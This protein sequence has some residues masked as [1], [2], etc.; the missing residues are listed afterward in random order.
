M[1]K[2]NQNVP[3]LTTNPACG[4]V[5]DMITHHGLSQKEVATAMKISPG[6]LSDII[7]GKKGVSAE[8]ALR[9]EH[10]LGLAADWLL[11]MQAHYDYCTAY[12]GKIPAIQKEV[13][14]LV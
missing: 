2:T 8:F 13:Q 3:R 6:L 10:C 7:R 5:A 14:S 1:M 11:R 12:H 9:F 4:M